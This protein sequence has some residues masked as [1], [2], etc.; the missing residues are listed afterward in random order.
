[1]HSQQSVKLAL[2][3]NITDRW[4]VSASMPY[5]FS[6]DNREGHTHQG[7]YKEIHN[8][9][10]VRGVGDATFIGSY[11]WLRDNKKGWQFSTGLGIKAPTGQT[12]VLS[13]T[14]IGLPPHLEP[15]TGSWDPVATLSV[16]KLMKQWTLTGDVFGKVAT[17]ANQH[18]MGDYVSGTATAFWQAW[19]NE[20]RL[21]SSLV[22]V[23]ALQSDFNSK[24]KMPQN[25][26]HTSSS[27]TIPDSP[28][29][30]FENSG[31]TRIFISGGTL[32]S[33]GKH[34]TIPC[35]FSIPV[36]QHLNG[37]QVKMQWKSTLGFTINF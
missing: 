26:I 24:M 14:G 19:E 17:T 10:N 13:S 2:Q 6:F 12:E 27:D 28:I 15:G 30:T 23:G 25:H 9:G 31:F 32:I 4:K 20:D 21:V 35:S 7:D 18:N 22:L 33:L 37:H 5:N 16:K 3:Y 34:F 11:Q 29:T 1:V 36:Y 8:Y